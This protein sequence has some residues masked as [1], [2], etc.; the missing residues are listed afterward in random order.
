MQASVVQI[1]TVETIVVVDA[2]VIVKAVSTVEAIAVPVSTHVSAEASVHI[3]LLPASI[4]WNR[5]GN[6]SNAA[7]ASVQ[8]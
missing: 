4:G 1:R 8:R 7:R 2:V 6:F 5:T 3:A